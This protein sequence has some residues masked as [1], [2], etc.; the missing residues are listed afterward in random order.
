VDFGDLVRT[1]SLDDVAQATQDSDSE[2]VPGLR[3][4]LQ[5]KMLLGHLCAVEAWCRENG[6]AFLSEVLDNWEDV[7]EA[8]PLS[9][10]ERARMQTSNTPPV[11]GDEEDQRILTF[12]AKSEKIAARLQPRPSISSSLTI[13]YLPR[14]LETECLAFTAPS[15]GMTY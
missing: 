1:A 6:A 5:A 4:H 11:R 2:L 8:L 14:I 10:S 7:L 3:D 12:L 15:R 13:G 9:V